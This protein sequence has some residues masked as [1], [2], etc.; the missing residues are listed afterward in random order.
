MIQEKKI[1]LQKYREKLL[2]TSAMAEIKDKGI[3]CVQI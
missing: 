3:L 2:A 1:M